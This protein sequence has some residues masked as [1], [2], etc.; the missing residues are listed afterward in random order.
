MATV[1]VT[2]VDSPSRFFCLQTEGKQEYLKRFREDLN[3]FYRQRA[4]V[5]LNFDKDGGTGSWFVVS[6]E[7]G[8]HRAVV[9]KRDGDKVTAKLVDRGDTVNTFVSRCLHL[10]PEFRNPS[11]YVFR[12]HLSDVKPIGKDLNW[13]FEATE[14][15]VRLVSAP[16]EIQI[17]QRGTA[18]TQPDDGQMSLPI[19]VFF[20]ESFV[21]D[22]FS[23]SREGIASMSQ[24]LLVSKLAITTESYD[25]ESGVDVDVDVDFDFEEKSKDRAGAVGV[26]NEWPPPVVPGDEAFL[27][28][29][30]YISNLGQIFVRRDSDRW[31]HKQMKSFFK[32]VAEENE[33]EDMK[34]QWTVGEDCIARYENLHWYRARVISVDPLIVYYVD[35][36]SP[37]RVKPCDLRIPHDYGNVPMMAVRIILDGVKPV[38]DSWDEAVLDDLYNLINYE[39]SRVRVFPSTPST[40]KLP[41]PCRLEFFDETRKCD[42]A[43]FLT[44]MGYTVRSKTVLSVAMTQ[45]YL[46]EAHN[47]EGSCYDDDGALPVD[48]PPIS[49]VTSAL[50]GDLKS[51]FPLSEFVPVKLLLVSDDCEVH[52]H[53]ANEDSNLKYQRLVEELR[54]DACTQPPVIPTKGV[55]VSV[56]YADQWCR[57][58]IRSPARSGDGDLVSVWLLDLA[59]TAKIHGSD[60]RRMSESLASIPPFAI[61]G[62]L[63]YKLTRGREEEA[64]DMLHGVVNEHA[65]EELFMYSLTHS[66]RIPIGELYLRSYNGQYVNIF[67]GV[68]AKGLISK[69]NVARS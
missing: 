33:K 27:G 25:F 46:T 51:V 64:L 52:V 23:V 45:E 41:V 69:D 49:A 37:G 16:R 50:D 68:L 32:A 7:G 2:H 42:V 44:E 36:G 22:P 54:Q 4:P 17:C 61:K 30:T 13:S 5:P 53:L 48:A 21:D 24:K 43:E 18:C 6:H 57:G 12:C 11:S 26:V 55:I 1:I 67:A 3:A 40:K 20:T 8:F 39:K 19:E 63:A 66:G 60:I 65:E 58:F 15:F 28:R 34:E 14:L 35:Y 31:L 9:L 29:V 62:G 47:I 38:H 10:T 56:R 59:G